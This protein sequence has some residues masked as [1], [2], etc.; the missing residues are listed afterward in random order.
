MRRKDREI[1]DFNE[2]VKIMEKCDVCRLA[3]NDDDYPYILPVNFGMKVDN[4]KVILYFHGAN[5][6]RKYE[7]LKRDNRAS[8]EMDCSHQLVFDDHKA[9]CTMKYE[10]V[11]G[12]GRIDILPEE[13]KMEALTIL[14]DRYHENHFEFGTAIVPRTIVMKLTVEEMTGKRR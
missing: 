13:D 12:K 10:S 6:G 9:E 2:I 11:I 14:T 4:G 3:L 1:T 8:F 7:I 5:Q